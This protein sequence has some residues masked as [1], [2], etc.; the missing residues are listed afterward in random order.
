MTNTDRPV[1][2]T[3]YDRIGNA[4]PKRVA[5]ASMGV[6]NAIQD[7][8]P[9]EQLAAAGV[10]MLALTRRFGVNPAN[11]LNCVDNL[12]KDSRRYDDATFQGITEYFK[13][14]L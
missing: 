12:M 3:V 11:I 5:T 14:E 1:V 10:L 4:N 9:D 8:P 6:L 7:R 13:H 2:Q